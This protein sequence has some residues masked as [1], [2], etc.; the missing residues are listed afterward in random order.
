MRRVL[1]LINPKSGLPRSF[2]G[3]RQALD[4]Y[5]DLEG[6][7]LI[8][9]F[10]QSK[11]DGAAKAR[12][13]VK[14]GFDTILVSGGDG[15]VSTIGRVLVNTDVSMGVIPTGSGNGFAR[16][17]G[18]P[19]SQ[20]RAVRMLAHA[21]VR[22]IDVG[23]VNDVPFF[24]TCSMA[25]DA[26]IVRYF[27]RSPVRGIIPYL[28][29]G[30]QGF[31]EYRPEDMDVEIRGPT[32]SL[33]LRKPIIFTIANLTQYGGGAKIAPEAK[34]DDGLLELVVGLQQDA[35]LLIANL[36][37]LFDGSLHR[38]PRLITRSF[39]S[40]KAARNT[41]TP[42]QIDGELLDAPREIN[43]SVIPEGLKVLVP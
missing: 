42:I 32:E 14:R 29:A 11:D 18:I 43:V 3:I 2:L 1:V 36:G 4:T 27:D 8:Y 34:E 6:V 19:L 40:L 41:A 38:I 13:A 7:D 24:V 17:F 33:H 10:S 35:P 20:G 12:R 31:L 21:S 22:M 26:A 9:Q 23:V 25:W 39:R 37:R 30:V 15:T 28:F 5:W 16:H